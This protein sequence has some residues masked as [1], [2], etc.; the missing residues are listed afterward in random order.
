VSFALHAVV[1]ALALRVY[2]HVRD[3]HGLAQAARLSAG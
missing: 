2:G 3:E 1:A